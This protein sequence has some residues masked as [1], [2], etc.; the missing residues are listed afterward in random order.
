MDEAICKKP[1]IKWYK[2]QVHLFFF[3]KTAF[4]LSLVA[5]NKPSVS[6]DD[7]AITVVLLLIIYFWCLM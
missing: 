5:E 3:L 2:V 1:P 6:G 7:D 4:S